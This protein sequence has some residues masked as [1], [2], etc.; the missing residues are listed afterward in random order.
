MNG[1][2]EVK[3]TA[4]DGAASD[5]FGFSVA[6]GENKIVVGAANDDSNTGSVYVY[7]LDGTGQTKITASDGAANDAF[8][9]L[10]L[11]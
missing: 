7:N 5:R 9:D 4:S 8:G 1:F 11:L 10:M 2:N 3:I 6:V